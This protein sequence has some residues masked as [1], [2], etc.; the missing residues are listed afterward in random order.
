MIKWSR[1]KAVKVDTPEGKSSISLH[2]AG[3]AGA[4]LLYMQ[5][6]L[7]DNVLSRILPAPNV[8]TNFSARG[9]GHTRMK[10]FPISETIFSDVDPVDGAAGNWLENNPGFGRLTVDVVAP[11]SFCWSRNQREV[12]ATTSTVPL[13]ENI[14]SRIAVE[15][16]GRRVELVMVIRKEAILMVTLQRQLFHEQL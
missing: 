16:I 10:C 5:N 6:F 13:Q 11:G 14:V 12:G 3:L 2:I 9:Y 4:Q 15:A 1:S 7:L 8:H